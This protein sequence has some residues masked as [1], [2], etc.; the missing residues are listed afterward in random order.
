M[1]LS[2]AFTAT[3]SPTTPLRSPYLPTQIW[4]P[5]AKSCWT[6]W[7][8]VE[9]LKQPGALTEALQG[10]GARHVKYGALPEHYPLVGN[11]LLKTF[12]QYLGD[13]WTGEVKQDWVDAYQVIT[14]VMLVG[15]DYDSK[16]VE[17]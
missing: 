13:A 10:L 7:F 2:V 5:S 16:D 9:N 11:T 6:R 12:E 1:P 17:I 3:C 4:K 15:A 8:L 14:E